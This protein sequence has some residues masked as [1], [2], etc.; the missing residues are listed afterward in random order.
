MRINHLK[1]GEEP[2]PETSCISNIPQWTMDNTVI[3]NQPLSQTC[4]ELLD[5]SIVFKNLYFVEMFILLKIKVLIEFVAGAERDLLVLNVSA[6][7][8]GHIFR[9]QVDSVPKYVDEMTKQ[10]YL[11]IR[12][13]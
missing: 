2:T 6:E 7:F 12:R 10:Q 11:R 9:T 13:S 8:Y 4:R 5:K 3:M 1:T